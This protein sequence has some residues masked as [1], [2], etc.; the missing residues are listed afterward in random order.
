MKHVLLMTRNEGSDH[1]I[2]AL[3][4]HDDVHVVLEVAGTI[5]EKE[6]AERYAQL[7]K[8]KYRNQKNCRFRKICKIVSINPPI[9]LW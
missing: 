7:C 9:K 1:I 8:T 6:I 2:E 4:E 3:M 5:E